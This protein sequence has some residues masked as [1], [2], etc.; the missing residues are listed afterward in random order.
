MELI[1]IVPAGDVE[2]RDRASPI[3]ISKNLALNLFLISHWPLVLSVVRRLGVA[4]V[5][6]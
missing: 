6:K 4:E 2:S 1:R 3:V 5:S